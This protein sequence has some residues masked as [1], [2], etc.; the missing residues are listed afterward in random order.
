MSTEAAKMRMGMLVQQNITFIWSHHVF[1]VF[2]IF[3]LPAVCFVLR[4][5]RL[6]FVPSDH[7]VNHCCF[8]SIDV[9]GTVFWDQDEAE[10]CEHSHDADKT[11]QIDRIGYRK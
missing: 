3:V 5:L 7:A 9:R 1:F 4:V 10:D 2:F 6:C 11:K 8:F